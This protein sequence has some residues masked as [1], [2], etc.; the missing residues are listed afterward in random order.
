M[1]SQDLLVL[2]MYLYI[3]FFLLFVLNEENCEIFE[4]T[5]SL[6][7]INSLAVKVVFDDMNFLKE[8]KIMK[9]A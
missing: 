5:G 4:K 6:K 1:L 9:N 2:Y 7:N 3:Y 8:K